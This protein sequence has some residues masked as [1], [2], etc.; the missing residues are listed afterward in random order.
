MIRPPPLST[1]TDTLLPSTTLFRSA[2]LVGHHLGV[3]I[4]DAGG[5]GDRFGT[6]VEAHELAV[7][8]VAADTDRLAQQGVEAQLRQARGHDV[9]HRLRPGHRSEEH[10]SEL[11]SLM[12]I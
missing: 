6:R 9:G 3:G 2:A 7:R 4:G 8:A 11:P 10:T 12:R 5:E 1:L